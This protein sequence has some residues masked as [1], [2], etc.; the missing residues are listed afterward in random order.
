MREQNGGAELTVNTKSLYRYRF[1][2]DIPGAEHFNF[3]LV[4]FFGIQE[5]VKFLIY[6]VSRM[7]SNTP[8][9]STLCGLQKSDGSKCSIH[10]FCI[11]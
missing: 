6:F 2:S 10:G 9:D 7:F 1:N 5:L 3:F 4:F 11:L 8:S